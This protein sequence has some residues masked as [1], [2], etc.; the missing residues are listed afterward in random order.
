M[1]SF[2]TLADVEAWVLGNG[3]N[4]ER[5]LQ[6]AI[7]ERRLLPNSEK[8]AQ[9]WLEINDKDVGKVLEQEDRELKAR[10]TMA[11]ERSAAAAK[12]SAEAAQQSAE[13]ALTANRRSLFAIV[14]ALLAAL[15][16]ALEYLK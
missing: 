11:A 13:A 1:A 9:R 6:K 2:N 3:L 10:A 16:A 14:V 12:A 7:A 8:L 15:V 5:E 4:G